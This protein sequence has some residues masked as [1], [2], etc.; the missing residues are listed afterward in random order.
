MCMHR[1][2]NE[3]GSC[4]TSL[5]ASP[6]NTNNLCVTA[7]G[8]ESGVVSLYQGESY[9]TGNSAA[10][11]L[12]KS[13]MNLSTRINSM[14]FHPSGQL[15]AMASEEVFHFSCVSCPHICHL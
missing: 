3:D 8:S 11:T 14:A 4:S 12:M 7:I 5:C 2:H 1:F 10:P 9:H 15:L 6:T 13:V